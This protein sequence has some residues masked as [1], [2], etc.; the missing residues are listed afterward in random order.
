MKKTLAIVGSQWGDEGKGKITDFFAQDADYIVRWSGGDNAGHTIF[1][2]NTKFKLSCIPSGIFNKN[3]IN[4][5]GNGCVL[6]LKQLIAEI[7]YLKEYGFDCNNLRISNR[8]HLIFPYHLDMDFYQEKNRANSIGTTQKGIGPTYQDKACRDGIRICDLA[9][10]KIFKQ[11]LTTNLNFRNQVLINIYKG[12]KFDCN[13]IFDEYKQY[14][15][16]ISKFVTDTSLLLHDA[17]NANKKVLFEGAQGVMLD[18][19]HGTYPFVTSSNPSAS[20]IPI[21]VGISPKYI[22]EILGI[23]KAYSTRVGEGPFPSEITSSL[24]DKIR[25]KGNEYGVRTGRPRRIGW[26]DIVLLKHAIRISGITSLAITLIDVLSELDELQI[27]TGYKLN[28]KVIEYIPP[29]INDYLKCKPIFITMSGWKE[30][31]K[32]VKK[33]SDLPTN[34]QLYIK[35]ISELLNI[36]IS[37]ISYGADRSQTII[38]RKVF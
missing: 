20:S 36:P 34:A 1:F 7:K 3:S 18:L 21:G 4:V 38:L 14:Y 11:K 26:L 9:D 30:S 16:E 2:N 27:C 33:L 13:Q 17:I 32:S 37:I 5:I 31:I 25:I 24:A 35:K 29:L 22:N 28:H 23:T 19:D 12:K 6:N 15:K 8:V 10:D